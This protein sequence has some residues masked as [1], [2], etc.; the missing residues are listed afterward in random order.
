MLL[1]SRYFA[2]TKPPIK[3]ANISPVQNARLL[4]SVRRKAGRTTKAGD[5]AAN[6]AREPM[7]R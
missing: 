6:A 1:T 7:Q 4:S 3:T 5:R 2:A